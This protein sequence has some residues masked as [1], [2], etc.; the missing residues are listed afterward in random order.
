MTNICTEKKTLC[1]SDCRPVS[2]PDGAGA[3]QLMSD[4]PLLG[5]GVTGRQVNQ[6]QEHLDLDGRRKDT[7]QREAGKTQENVSAV[8]F[9]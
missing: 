8:I 1:V 6:I 9:L 4:R 3:G 7:N 2:H 5:S